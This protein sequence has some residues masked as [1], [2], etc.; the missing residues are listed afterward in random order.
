MRPRRKRKQREEMVY[1]SAQF[2]DVS[3]LFCR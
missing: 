3:R 2:I 1:K